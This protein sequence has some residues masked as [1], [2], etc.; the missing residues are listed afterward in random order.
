MQNKVLVTGYSGFVGRHL[1]E[2]LRDKYE[3]NLVGRKSTNIGEVFT[4]PIDG[5]VDLSECFD[6]VDCV[7]HLAARVHVMND[8][9][10]NSLDEFRKVNVACTTTLV[11]Q[12]IKAGVKRF[13]YISTIKVNGESA[14]IQ[15]PFTANDVP[16]PQDAYGKSK[17]EA[18]QC[19]IDFTK[20]SSMEFVIIRPPLVYGK[21]VKANFASLMKLTGKGYPLPFGGIHQNRRSLVSVYNLVDLI[22]VCIEHPHARN[23]IFLVSDDANLSTK[24]LVS[25]MASVQ[26]KQAFLLHLPIWLL[27][28]VGFLTAKQKVVERLTGSLVVDIAETKNLLNWEPPLSVQCGF[29]KSVPIKRGH[30]DN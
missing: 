5:S 9:G 14:S 19:L 27:K 13:I 30:K 15:K 26:N 24:E 29:K 12:A 22:R 1:L 25:L 7:I 2:V 3:L 8:N 28:L 11:K 17:A 20:N 6:G 4:L 23:K 21:G 16:D 10:E 18:E